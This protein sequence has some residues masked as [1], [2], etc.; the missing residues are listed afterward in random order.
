MNI[1]ILKMFLQRNYSSFK[2][3]F[4][5]YWQW[6]QFEGG[7]VSLSLIFF[8]FEIFYCE[9]SGKVFLK[10]EKFLWTNIF[11]TE[12]FIFANFVQKV[13]IEWTQF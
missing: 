1:S 13:G 11:T 7:R 4:P 6:R 3:T 12:M 8:F 5:L 2:T 9:Y 10:L